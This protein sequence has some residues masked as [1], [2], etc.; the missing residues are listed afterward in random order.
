M[1][2]MAFR[3]LFAAAL[4]FGLNLGLGTQA[5]AAPRLQLHTVELVGYVGKALKIAVEI[6]CGG[7]FYGLVAQSDDRGTLR[8]AAAVNQDSIV[9]TSMPDPREMV[10]DYLHT[11]GFKSIAPMRLD[12]GPNRVNVAR[13][14][15]LRMT[16]GKN[17]RRLRLAYESKCGSEMG[18][19]IR[20]TGEGRLEIGY[21]EK[22]ATA[23]AY[24]IAC[25]G[26]ERVRFVTALDPKEKYTV[27]SLREKPAS[28]RKAFYVRLAPI[29]PAS[30]AKAATGNNGVMV[31]YQRACNEAP[32]GVVV[33]RVESK[34]D[35]NRVKIGVLVARY[36]NMPCVKGHEAAQWE[37]YGDHEIK[38][39]RG[40]DVVALAS[41][42]GMDALT[43]LEPRKLKRLEK[44]GDKGVALSYVRPC[45]AEIGAVYA[46]DGRRK[47]AVAA[48]ARRSSTCKARPAEVSL[49][50]PFVA[51]HVKASDLHPMRLSGSPAH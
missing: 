25:D 50:Q 33:S 44:N 38:I 9:C 34:N 3:Y 22:V 41:T 37:T 13:V 14:N 42:T 17:G 47:L 45:G 24:G 4:V 19:L 28:L 43:L 20:R 35:R 23:S 32:V 12:S 30:L 18:A 31:R 29:D 26:K 1:V 51:Q 21:V 40:T 36:Y 39:P 5:Q 6:P 49:F 11:T 7:E 8:L 46:R 27:A 2:L 16:D 10:V 15:D 48:L